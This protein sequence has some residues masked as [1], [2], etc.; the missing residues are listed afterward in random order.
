[1]K[2]TLLLMVLL[3]AGGLPAGEVLLFHDDFKDGDLKGGTLWTPKSTKEPWTV[4]SG[5]VTASGKIPFDALSTSDFKP[6]VN[7]VFDLRFTV[8][9]DSAEKS[10][11][12]RFSVYLRDSANRHNGYG[13]TIAQGTGNN[14]GIERLE[15]G[16]VSGLCPLPPGKVF[17]FPPGKPVEVRFTRSADGALRLFI[18]GVQ[19]MEA[20]DARFSR[21]DRV[22]FTLRCKTAALR[23]A[24]GNV[25]LFTENKQ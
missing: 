18:D 1:M 13:A 12:N 20:T 8:T 24:V 3:M 25:S 15:D 5:A 10:G 4:A 9:F 2:I 21:F 14:S 6:I 19:R 22:Q 16:K 7:G 11:D 17:F 23:Q